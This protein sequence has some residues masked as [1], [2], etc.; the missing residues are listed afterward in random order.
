MT[1]RL[2]RTKSS[3]K[4]SKRT[5]S[6]RTSKK[7]KSRSTTTSKNTTRGASKRSRPNNSEDKGE[8]AGPEN[9]EIEVRLGRGQ[10]QRVHESCFKGYTLKKILGQGVYGTVAEFCLNDNCDYAVKLVRKDMIMSNE[11][12]VLKELSD[13]G[14]GPK[15]IDSWDCLSSE[16]PSEPQEDDYV[17]L[18]VTEKWDAELPQSVCI[19]EQIIMK[20]CKQIKVLHS[21]GYV[22][23]DILEKNVLIRK[24]DNEIV[25]A[26]LT[27][28]GT[29]DKIA[30]WKQNPDDV[31]LFFDYHIT[32]GLN[33]Y[34]KDNNITLKDVQADPTH[35]DKALMWK[36]R[37]LCESQ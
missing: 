27:D 12:D 31:K 34:Y 37:K 32:G 6:K 7:T 18:I 22:H 3:K 21:L 4:T 36:L 33:S 23:G 26:T 11:L 13:N 29:V 30:V 15:F 25:D 19:N 24:K 8:E 20:L 2:G 28:F 5:T 35:L 10:I 1:S 17:T 16:N 14:V 9:E